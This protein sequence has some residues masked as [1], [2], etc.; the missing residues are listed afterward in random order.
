MTVDNALIALTCLIAVMVLFASTSSVKD[1]IRNIRCSRNER[2]WKAIVVSISIILLVLASFAVVSGIVYFQVVGADF[3]EE[4]I[5]S[6]NF[7]LNIIQSVA[8]FFH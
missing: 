1:I 4:F 3:E 7:V 6:K 2:D 5:N 8:K